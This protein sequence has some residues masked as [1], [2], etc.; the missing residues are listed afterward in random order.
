MC[1]VLQVAGHDTAPSPGQPS[2]TANIHNA[3]AGTAVWAS[4]IS[5]PAS[6]ICGSKSAEP[7]AHAYMFVA[8]PTTCDDLRSLAVAVS[9]RGAAAARG[10]DAAEVHCACLLHALLAHSCGRRG[11]VFPLSN[12]VMVFS[13]LPVDCRSRTASLS[14]AANSNHAFWYRCCLLDSPRHLMKPFGKAETCRVC[15]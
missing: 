1:L 2:L 15:P 7:A 12:L 8:R 13:V 3:A 9:S 10:R 4:L 6:P 11:V 5:E 14:R